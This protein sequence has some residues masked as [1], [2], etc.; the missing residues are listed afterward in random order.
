M[1]KGGGGE[2]GFLIGYRTVCGSYKSFLF[3]LIFLLPP[4][5]HTSSTNMYC[6]KCTF[7]YQFIS[8]SPVI[9]SRFRFRNG[10]SKVQK[11]LGMFF[12]VFLFW[13]GGGDLWRF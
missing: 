4:G 5:S 13:G 1:E 7:F 8:P 6:T 9:L 11:R 12:F 3:N 10:G 2:W